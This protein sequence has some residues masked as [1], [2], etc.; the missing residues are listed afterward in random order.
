MW[1]TP[2]PRIRT[3]SINIYKMKQSSYSWADLFRNKELL[4]S[5]KESSRQACCVRWANSSS[6]PAD[7]AAAPTYIFARTTIFHPSQRAFT[8]RPA[9]WCLMLMMVETRRWGG[10]GSRRGVCARW[11]SSPRAHPRK[12]RAISYLFNHPAHPF[13]S[14]Y[15][16]ISQTPCC[17]AHGCVSYSPLH[18]KATRERHYTAQYVTSVFGRFL[19]LQLF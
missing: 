8:V 4:L 11:S 16:C 18:N 6:T 13:T 2:V 3:E 14:C 7:S 15:L 1:T 5:R 10:W 19:C 17:V 9:W 12:R